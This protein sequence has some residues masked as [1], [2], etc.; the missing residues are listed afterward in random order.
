MSKIIV[1]DRGLNDLK[2]KLRNFK[3]AYTKVGYPMEK[4]ATR[5]RHKDTK[6]LTVGE[7]AIIQEEGSESRGI[8]MRKTILPAFNKNLETNKTIMRRTGTAI[9]NNS[10]MSIMQGLKI[11]GEVAANQITQEIDLIKLPILAKRTLAARRLK[12]NN[13]TKPLVFSGQMKRAVS[14]VEVLNKRDRIK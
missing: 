4:P 10:G 3:D 5:E 8:P 6:N 12:G 7:I 9:L 1:Y 2:N 13:S 11:I 14:H